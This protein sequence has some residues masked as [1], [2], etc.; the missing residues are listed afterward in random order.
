MKSDDYFEFIEQL[1]KAEDPPQI[2]IANLADAEKIDSIHSLYLEQLK[3][4]H[5]QV[6]DIHLNGGDTD[7]STLHAE[8]ATIPMFDEIRLLWVRHGSAIFDKINANKVI[9]EYFVRDFNNIPESTNMLLQLDGKKLPKA[10]ENLTKKAWI[11]QEKPLKEKDLPSFIKSRVRQMG[12]EIEEGAVQ[13]LS[14]RYSFN[15]ERLNDALNRLFT[16]CLSEKQIYQKDIDDICFDTHGN[17]VFTI[18]D[19]LA[20]KKITE[21]L[22]ILP[23]QRFSD[24]GM[25]VS[26]IS[27]LFIESMRSLRLKKCNM[28]V[29]EVHERMGLNTKHTFIIRKNEDRMLKVNS[30]YSARSYRKIY[31]ALIELDKRMKENSTEEMHTTILTMFIASLETL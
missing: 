12:F 31:P 8:F 14:E 25:L 16:Y 19:L 3:K 20:E 2:I 11:L 7:A 26:L 24:F 13:L 29:K 10:F 22:K 28:G 17:A 30:N 27:K 9:K 6:D 1:K 18:L 4:H 15:T 23:E 21:L 5:T